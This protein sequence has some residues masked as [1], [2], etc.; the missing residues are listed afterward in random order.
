MSVMDDGLWES[1]CQDNGDCSLV[2]AF[3]LTVCFYRGPALVLSWRDGT[4]FMTLMSHDRLCLNTAIHRFGT[5]S[6]IIGV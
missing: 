2:L 1:R 6:S 4:D 3:L 5:Y